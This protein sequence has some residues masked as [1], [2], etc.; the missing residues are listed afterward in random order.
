M[1]KLSLNPEALRVESFATAADV[2]GRGTVRANAYT[3]PDYPSCARTCGA[4][5]PPDT[6]I[7]GWGLRP[8][9]KACCL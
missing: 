7:C 9:L 4:S 2:P 1:K 6:E 3:D 5:P 8:T